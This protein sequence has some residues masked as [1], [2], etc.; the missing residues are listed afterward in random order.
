M[1]ALQKYAKAFKRLKA[2]LKPNLF[3]VF[4]SVFFV[5]LFGC[6]AKNS[7]DDEETFDEQEVISDVYA[8]GSYCAQVTYYY[9]KTGTSSEY[10]LEVDIEN[11]LLTKIHWPNGGWLDDTHFDPPEIING[12]ASFESDRGVE[13][14]VKIIGKEGN[15][16][17]DSSVDDDLLSDKYTDEVCPRCGNGK[18]SWKE[19][20]NRCI[21]KQENTCAKCGDY[22]YGVYGGLCNNC[23]EE[24]TKEATEA[25][26]EE[27]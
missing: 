1:L 11:G 18:Y 9:S 27:Y 6:N 12:E 7:S 22:E 4:C 23:Q 25:P 19:Y 24:E 13:Y 14:T 5:L 15:C 8:D 20:C 17:T 2:L 3:W 10:T 16:V 21:D 26:E